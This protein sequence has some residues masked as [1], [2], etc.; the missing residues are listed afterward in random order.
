VALYEAQGI[1]YDS[2][3]SEDEI[4]PELR[5][6][7]AGLRLAAFRAFRADHYGFKVFWLWQ[8]QDQTPTVSHAILKFL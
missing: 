7:G 2:E 1:D 6:T 8:T 3:T 4:H 5:F